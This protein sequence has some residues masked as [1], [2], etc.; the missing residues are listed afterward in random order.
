MINTLQSL[1]FIFAI[2]FLHHFAVNDVGLFEAEGSCGGFS[3]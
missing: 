2:I 1:R 3:L